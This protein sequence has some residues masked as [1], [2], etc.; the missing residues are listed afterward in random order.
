M[1]LLNIAPGPPYF[2]GALT[3]RGVFYPADLPTSEW[4]NYYA[5]RFDTVEINASFYSRPTW[6]LNGM[7]R[8]LKPLCCEAENIEGR[9]P[10]P[11]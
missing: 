11:G 7:R 6:A 10:Y 3:W 2:R 1:A 8:W 4:F 9:Q 5:R